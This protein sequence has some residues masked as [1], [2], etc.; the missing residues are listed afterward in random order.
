MY[1]HNRDILA[2]IVTNEFEAAY[3][4]DSPV[5]MKEARKKVK[6]YLMNLLPVFNIQR[7]EW[8]LPPEQFLKFL[9]QLIKSKKD[10]T[11]NSQLHI[12][13]TGDEAV[14]ASRL[15]GNTYSSYKTSFNFLMRLHGF[16]FSHGWKEKLNGIFHGMVNTFVKKAREK[17]VRLYSGKKAM[18]ILLLEEISS[19]Y[20][21]EGERYSWFDKL[22][23]TLSWCLMCRTQNTCKI[24]LKHMQW[25]KDALT[26]HFSGSKT[27][28]L[29]KRN[30][31][32]H[33]YANPKRPELCPILALGLFWC[34]FNSDLGDKD[35]AL[36]SGS[37]QNKRFNRDLHETF[38]IDD[39][40]DLMK[41]RGLEA[42]EFGTHSLRKGALTA[43]ACGTTAAPSA[44]A[45]R[46]RAG[47]KGIGVESIY[48]QYE[49]AGD[50][51]V[52][53]VAS[54]LPVL[55]PE[56]IALPPRF[57][58]RTREERSKYLSI[59][60]KGFTNVPDYLKGVMQMVVATLV[61]HYGFIRRNVPEDSTLYDTNF[62]TEITKEELD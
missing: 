24:K 53:R 60:E 57:D 43:S 15:A 1:D 37:L 17:N 12:A 19:Y 11:L 59:Q 51:Y 2:T 20:I 32:R 44:H 34:E 7:C 14:E 3:D 36:F 6:Y 58:F 50:Q 31:A 40:D 26:I 25:T 55:S 22:Y 54:L 9:E 45:L 48:I 10:T 28:E 35:G 56:F 47:W 42:K 41:F 61:F 5:T 16:T 30:P 46:V 23:L 49:E 52:G 27:D 62:F 33:I 29:G 21:K 4:P 13:E 39:I 38:M 8:P 18:P